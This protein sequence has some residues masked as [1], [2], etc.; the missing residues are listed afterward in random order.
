MPN[1]ACHLNF[2][3]Q[4]TSMKQKCKSTSMTRGW[5]S[6]WSYTHVQSGWRPQAHG[7]RASLGLLLTL[8]AGFLAVLLG[9]QSK[10]AES[11]PTFTQPVFYSTELM[12]GP[13][14]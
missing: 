3:S 2:A 4:G 9:P 8:T 7:R 14:A 13:V 11:C 6:P 10:A 1:L 5:D 12:D